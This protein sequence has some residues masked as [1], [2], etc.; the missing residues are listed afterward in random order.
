MKIRLP[1]AR[2]RELDGNMRSWGR[3]GERAQAD[4][5]A[6]TRAGRDLDREA[7]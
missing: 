5:A 7:G 4:A 3:G 6:V 2:T 1:E